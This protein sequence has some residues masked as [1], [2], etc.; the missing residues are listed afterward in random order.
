MFNPTKPDH[1]LPPKQIFTWRTAACTEWR[2]LSVSQMTLC[3][4]LRSPSW[5]TTPPA[6]A[7][8]PC[9]AS[10]C[11]RPC[12]SLPSSSSSPP[13][14]TS[15]SVSC[16]LEE[17]PPNWSSIFLT[18][19]LYLNTAQPIG[20]GQRWEEPA[21][22]VTAGSTG[23]FWDHLCS[24]MKVLLKLKVRFVTDPLTRV[25]CHQLSDLSLCRPT[26]SRVFILVLVQKPKF[27]FSKYHF[28]QIRFFISQIEPNLKHIQCL[29]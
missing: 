25:K 21:A 10:P 3:T 6:A 13:H 7:A 29:F 9:L 12:C 17:K 24:V 18:S 5:Q 16:R 1:V 28:L 26:D 2:V 15:S 19:D 11:C 20:G 22:E 23:S 27:H 4:S 14:S 8:S